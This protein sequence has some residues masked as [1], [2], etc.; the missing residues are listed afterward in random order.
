MAETVDT[1]DAGPVEDIA[2]A[3]EDEAEESEEQE[4]VSGLVERLGRD[5]SA[6]TFYEVQLAASHGSRR[7]GR[8]CRE[9]SSSR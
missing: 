2:D 7:C 6:L 1:D 3:V 8:P 5:A 9:S 4:T